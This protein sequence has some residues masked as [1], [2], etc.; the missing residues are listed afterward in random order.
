M[1]INAKNSQVFYVLLIL[2]VVRFSQNIP[3]KWIISNYYFARDEEFFPKPLELR[4]TCSGKI[5]LNL[6]YSRNDKKNWITSELFLAEFYALM[7]QNLCL[8]YSK[9]CY[10]YSFIWNMFAFIFEIIWVKISFISWEKLIWI[11]KTLFKFQ[12]LSFYMWVDSNGLEYYE[13]L[14]ITV[15]QILLQTKLFTK[16]FFTL[17]T[18]FH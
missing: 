9:I 13:L 17:K 10:C 4:N 16:T 7:K 2:W 6:F 5:N 3:D 1:R 18:I 11:K 12:I 14:V 15:K 8:K